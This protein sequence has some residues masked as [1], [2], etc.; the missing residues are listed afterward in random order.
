MAANKIYLEVVFASQDA[1][2]NIVQLNKSIKGIGDAAEEGSKKANTN[3][4]SVQVTVESTANSFKQMGAALAGLGIGMAVK[5]L[6]ALG[7]ELN[8]IQRAVASMPGAPQALKD[9][10]EYAKRSTFSVTALYDNFNKLRNAGMS[11]AAAA[12]AVK[13]FAQRADQAR[14]GQDDLNDTVQAFGNIINQQF[15]TGKSLYA[16]F[17]KSGLE[18]MGMLREATGKTVQQIR[19]DTRLMNA[20]VVAQMILVQAKIKNLTGTGDSGSVLAGMNQ[21]KTA[22]V[23]FG[24]A[25]DDVLGPSIARIIKL[26]IIM[27]NAATDAVKAMKAIPEPVRDI[28]VGLGTAA[29]VGY[30]GYKA[31][32]YGKAGIAGVQALLGGAAAG[33]AGGAVAGAAGGAAAGAGGAAMFATEIAAGPAGWTVLI[34]TVVAAVIAYLA[35]SGKGDKVA[36][37]A[38]G[39]GQS[40]KDKEIAS[41]KA[42]LAR[43]S[44]TMYSP[45]DAKMAQQMEIAQNLLSEA[46][47][48]YFMVGKESIAALSY[49]YEEHFRRVAGNAKATAIVRVAYEKSIDTEVR[50]M[51]EERRKDSLK[52]QEELLVL[53]RKTA[54]TALSVIPDQTYSGRQRV[55]EATARDFEQQIQHQTDIQIKEYDRQHQAQID[56]Q[57]KLGQDTSVIQKEMVDNRVEEQAKADEKVKEHRLVSERETNILLEELAKERRQAEADFRQAGLAAEREQLLAIAQLRQA[58]TLPQRLEQIKTVEAIELA[59]IEKMHKARLDALDKEADALADLARRAG[60]E[61]GVSEIDERYSTQRAQLRNQKEADLQVAR[62]NAWKETDA[63][64]LEEQKSMY[65]SMKSAAD[66][67]WN[68]FMDRSQSV[69]KSI[70]NAMKAAITGAIKDITT[71]RLAAGLTE[72]FG[73]GP[74]SFEGGRRGILGNRPIF[75]GNPA[76]RPGAVPWTSAQSG[77]SYSLA[78]AGTALSGSALALNS[79]AQALITAASFMGAPSTGYAARSV[80]DQIVAQAQTTGGIGGADLPTTAAAA[81]SPPYTGGYGSPTNITTPTFNPPTGSFQR[82]IE[83]V[84]RT[85]GLGHAVQVVSGAGSVTTVPWA[86]ATGMQ[87][88]GSILKSPGVMSLALGTGAMIAMQGLQRGGVL[89]N[90]Q[91]VGGGALAG[92]GLAGTFPAL[93]LTYLGGALLGAGVGVAAAGLQRGGKVGLGM[94]IGGGALAGAVAGTAIFPGLGTAAGALIGAAI[95]GI[96]GLIRLVSPTLTERIRP[97]IRRIYGV[98]ITNQSVIQQIADIVKQKY[99]GNLSIGVYS[100]E[101]QD[102]VRLYS[103]STGQSQAGL[104]RPMYAAN[105]AQSQVGGLALQPVY[106]GGQMIASPYT[107]TTT[108]QLSNALFTNPAVYL[109]LHP[110]QAADL[111]AGQ[112]VQVLGNNPGSVAAANTAAARNGQSRT[113]QGSALLEPLTVMR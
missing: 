23:E 89:G 73:G 2:Q 104:P 18:V 113:T 6:Y 4:K 1:Q 40:A 56:A 78:S 28:G 39:A 84:G 110:Q 63:A 82:A 21:L 43:L 34:G 33:A 26:L 5:E 30:T 24:R 49:E 60:N 46:Q 25:L 90:A 65:A 92:V 41:L 45:D 15:V 62:L 61:A 96:A 44:K 58:Q 36:A 81:P 95:G 13:T 57:K 8:R 29:V 97:E 32:Q 76:E 67:I 71:S 17:G 111:F 53:Q 22:F 112:V 16:Q 37:A 3:L 106:S 87:R 101:V 94:S 99:G 70:G 105:F 79:A 68:A 27:V 59:S 31:I 72:L 55:A 42:E 51:E 109:Q 102:I 35:F 93:G 50:K 80:N 52:N 54:V 83:G 75:S 66:Q 86:Q 10:D 64:I 47:K 20:E 9:L 69:W 74:V 107:G 77:V 108:T 100:Q 19:T 38:G 98:D 12:D 7:A 85:I 88:L 91:T 14:K 103:L 48:K 11:A